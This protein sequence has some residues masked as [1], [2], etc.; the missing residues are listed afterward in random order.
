L[1]RNVCD[2]T[3]E[4]RCREE[5]GSE[6]FISWACSKCDKKKSRELHPWTN[7]I[8]FLR[9]LMK[10]GYPFCKNDLSLEEWLDLG[11]TNE[12]IESKTKGF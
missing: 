11:M 8:L 2:P 12:L 4:A 6:E 3:E 7:H 1:S 5:I 9:I 10:A